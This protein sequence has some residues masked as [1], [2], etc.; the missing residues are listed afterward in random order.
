[1]RIEVDL[2]ETGRA[3]ALRNGIRLGELEAN[4]GGFDFISSPQSR[5]RQTMEII[6]RALGLPVP[7]YR[8][9]ERLVELDYGDW[10]GLTETETRRDFPELFARR[11]ADKWNFVPPGSQA[12]S[13]AMQAVRLSPFMESLE[14]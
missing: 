3:Q 7:D 6:R 11:T 4:S 14:R 5:A 10:Q 2:D 9:D 8:T 12:E 13:Y 1:G